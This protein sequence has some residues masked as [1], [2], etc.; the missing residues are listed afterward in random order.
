MPLDRFFVLFTPVRFAVVQDGVARL[1]LWCSS[2]WFL[3]LTTCQLLRMQ[4][5]LMRSLIQQFEYLFV[6]VE[7]IL[8]L[9]A[10]LLVLQDNLEKTAFSALVYS[11]FWMTAW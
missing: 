5:V 3:V 7:L 8:A 9:L 6:C 1:T 10:G 2:I 4:L 11:T